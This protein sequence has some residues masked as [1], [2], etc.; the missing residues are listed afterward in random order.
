MLDPR[1]RKKKKRGGPRYLGFACAAGYFAVIIPLFFLGW[2]AKFFFAGY[3]SENLKYMMEFGRKAAEGLLPYVH[4]PVEY[5]PLS[6]A[7]LWLMAPF[8]GGMDTY[9]G[10][11]GMGMAAIS[12]AG[13]LAAM[14]I[15]ELASP[16]KNTTGRQIAAAALYTIAIVCIG[17]IGVVSMDYIP[18]ALSAW[19]LVFLLREKHA[20][21]F[22][23][24]AA[25]AGAKGYPVFLLPVF[26]W[27][28]YNTGGRPALLKSAA[29]FAAT[30]ALVFVPPLLA[31]PRGFLDS[32]GYHAGRGIEIGSFYSAA[33]ALLKYAGVRVSVSFGHG[34][35]NIEAGAL[36]GLLA[37]VSPLV[38]LLLAAACY[39]RFIPAAR[40]GRAMAAGS[41]SVVLA[42]II[43]FKVGS[44]Q[45][46]CWLA[47]FMPAVAMLRRG[48]AVFISFCAAGLLALWLFPWH[49]QSLVHLDTTDTPVIPVLV[50]EK[51]LLLAVFAML[52]LFRPP[53]APSGGDVSASS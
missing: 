32:F 18:M 35:W 31:A 30:C 48:W 25:S 51:L 1:G 8:S 23:L 17:P 14:R 21:A 43:G 50:A 19:A 5:P 41:A 45:F 36:S 13:L 2:P 27:R 15:A 7:W 26:L 40:D 6:A 12:A 28:A 10:I 20:A 24:L 38:M 22:A 52:L 16:G 46:L 33:L 37:G 34:G 11:F 44:P 3:V 49:M 42:F 9:S 53:A 39:A 47:P 29:W 4:V